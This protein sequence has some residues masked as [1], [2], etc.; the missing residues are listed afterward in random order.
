MFY[1]LREMLVVRAVRSVVCIE[2]DADGLGKVGGVRNVGSTG[3]VD[4]IN[5]GLHC[6]WC[7]IRVFGLLRKKQ[8]RFVAP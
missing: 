5:N 6:E 8:P 4:N 2:D 7:Y 3:S 1:A